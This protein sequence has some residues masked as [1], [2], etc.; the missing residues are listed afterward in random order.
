MQISTL[1]K[2]TAFAAF[3]A[4]TTSAFAAEPLVSTDWLKDN[5]NE[6]NLVLIDVRTKL[7][8]TGREDYLK[9]HIPGAV[10]T[11]YPGFWRSDEGAVV[12]VLPSVEKL[13]ASLSQLGVGEDKHVVIYPAGTS[14]TDFGV[15]ARLYWTLKHLGHEEVSILD[16]GWQAWAAD[17]SNPVGTGEVIPEPDFFEASLV[18]GLNIST[19][20]VSALL[21]SDT[22]FVDARPDAQFLG[23]EKHPAATR[24]GRLPGAVQADNH[25]FFDVETGRLKDRDTL[26]ALVPASIDSGSTIVSYCNTGHWAATNWFVM[27][28]VL[29]F[30]DVALYDESMVGW[31]QSEFE[32]ESDRTRLDDFRD[33]IGRVTGS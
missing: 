15:A 8:N 13:E 11:D 2:T 9:A 4:S 22:V 33:W 18:D 25:G 17:A 31:S 26:A 5:L 7:A 27:S 29:G 10:W 32:V 28:E 20:D 12:G 30:E 19:A 21:G 14:A 24:F 16:G 23:Q 3:L 1:A 6:D